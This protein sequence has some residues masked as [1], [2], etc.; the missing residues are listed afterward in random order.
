MAYNND[1]KY[2]LVKDTYYDP[3]K[4]NLI[5]IP[6]RKQMPNVLVFFVE[7]F[8]ARALGVYGS[9]LKNITPSLNQFAQHSL[10]VRNYYN[11]T[12]A[13]N[14][15]LRGQL[16]S[17]YPYLENMKFKDSCMNR[18]LENSGYETYFATSESAQRQIS[19]K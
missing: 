7:G 2:P 4:S 16:C 5:L 9:G 12:A 6:K 14:R 19:M 18:L 17:I 11:H 15:G 1:E 3:K 10:V 13:T 8:S